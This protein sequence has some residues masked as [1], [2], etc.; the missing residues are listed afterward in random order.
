MPNSEHFK[1]CDRVIELLFKFGYIRMQQDY[2]VKDR[3]CFDID[4]IL[5]DP[6]EVLAKLKANWELEK[7]DSKGS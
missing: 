3:S 7:N 2:F 6:Y 4:Q 5:K 1:R